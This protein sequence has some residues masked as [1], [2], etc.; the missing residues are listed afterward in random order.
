MNLPVDLLFSLPLFCFFSNSW[1]SAK[2][3][4]LSVSLPSGCPPLSVPPAIPSP[5]LFSP[6][7]YFRL[8]SSSIAGC[9]KC[10]CV[11]ERN[12][13]QGSG[14]HGLGAGAWGRTLTQLDQNAQAG[15]T[16]HTHTHTHTRDLPNIAFPHPFFFEI[17]EVKQ[18]CVTECLKQS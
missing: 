12:G 3:I 14:C 18:T 7:I 17:L 11:A 5:V 6:L 10:V 16:T 1:C 13:D 8:Q 2:V 4:M 9:G 15:P